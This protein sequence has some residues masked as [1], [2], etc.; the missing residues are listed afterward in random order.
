[1]TGEVCHTTVIRFATPVVPIQPNLRASK[2]T[3]WPLIAWCSG[4]LLTTVPMV[5]PSFGAWLNMKFDASTWPPPGMF[6]TII[7]GLPGI[8][9]IQCLISIRAARSTG[10]PAPV[11]TTTVMVLT[12]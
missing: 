7:A 9:R 10:P 11:L 2:R 3:P 1:L 6:F 8:W 12:L 4:M 5:V